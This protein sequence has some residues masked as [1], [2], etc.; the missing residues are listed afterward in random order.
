MKINK[1]Y[2]KHI[3]FSM[4]V[5][6]LLNHVETVNLTLCCRKFIIFVVQS[7]LFLSHI[8]GTFYELISKGL[9][10]VWLAFRVIT[11]LPNSEQ[12]LCSIWWKI[13][14]LYWCQNIKDLRHL[15]QKLALQCIENL[16]RRIRVDG[17]PFSFVIML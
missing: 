17:K 3:L 6:F 13:T 14:S 7:T 12:N 4:P 15:I 8:F 9:H 2:K 11:S 5:Y 10:R 1:K 16:F